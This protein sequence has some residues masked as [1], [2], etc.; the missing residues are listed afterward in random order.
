M[1]KTLILVTGGAGYIGSHVCKLLA[2]R[3]FLPVVADDLSH[4]HKDFVKWGP[5]VQTSI[6]N[7]S[8][9]TRLIELYQ[10]RAVMHFAAKSLVGESVEKPDLYNRVNVG[11][12]KALLAK[13]EEH[14]IEN[15]V[16]SSTAATYGEPKK[17]PISE[18]DAPAPKN[19]YGES[20]LAIDNMIAAS[21]FSAISLRYF[22]VAG[23]GYDDLGDTSVA[24]SGTAPRGD[25]SHDDRGR[26]QEV[27]F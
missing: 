7:K 15:L 6:G 20:K 26:V 2:K 27:A 3:G 1:K 12:S 10:P 18:S 24:D 23:A 25:R 17:V 4:G 22:N 16:F 5:L 11:G 19:P 21:G 9:M 8:E 14:K 13:M